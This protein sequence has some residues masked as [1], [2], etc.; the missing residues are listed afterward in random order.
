M[1]KFRGRDTNTFQKKISFENLLNEDSMSKILS[2]PEF[3]NL[4]SE[5]L[6]IDEPKSNFIQEENYSL[7]HSCFY[8]RPLE[9]FCGTTFNDLMAS[10]G[11]GSPQIL[12]QSQY[13]R[14]ISKVLERIPAFK[15]EAD[16]FLLNI[17]RD[18]IIAELRPKIFKLLKLL[19]LEVKVQKFT[20]RN[21]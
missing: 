18:P 8:N 21:L 16:S 2:D 14:H 3:W 11:Y 6:S 17:F 1:N 12:S 20:S 10:C 19:K 13:P 4:S 15:E 9:T 7:E 5:C